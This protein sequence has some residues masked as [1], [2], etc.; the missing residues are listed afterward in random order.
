ME[1][2]GK[3]VRAFGGALVRAAV[4]PDRP[5]GIVPVIQT[6]VFPNHPVAAFYVPDILRQAAPIDE[7]GFSGRSA[8]RNR[9]MGGGGLCKHQPI[10]RE[11]FV[12]PGVHLRVSSYRGIPV[13][14]QAVQV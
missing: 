3:D 6:G 13:A 9:R 1:G 10:T 5:V 11:R 14:L 2:P 7:V 12:Q 8:G 4:L